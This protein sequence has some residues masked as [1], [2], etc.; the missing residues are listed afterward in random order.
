MGEYF[1]LEKPEAESMAILSTVR[2]GGSAGI[3]EEGALADPALDR[4][5]AGARNLD[6]RD[7]ERP[8]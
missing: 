3:Y 7:E 4:G 2:G 1:Y 6:L 8:R 5:R